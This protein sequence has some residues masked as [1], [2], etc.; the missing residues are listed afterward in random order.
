MWNDPLVTP[1]PATRPKPGK[2]PPSKPKATTK[3]KAKPR[4][5]PNTKLEKDVAALKE[6]TKA[7]AVTIARLSE[8]VSTMQ[9]SDTERFAGVT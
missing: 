7:Q 2:A 3:K 1:M 6:L 8:I 4:A 5:K 9:L